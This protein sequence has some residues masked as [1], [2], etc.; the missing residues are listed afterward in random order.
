M[1]DQNFAAGF[2]IGIQVDANTL[3]A[4]IAGLS[5]ALTSSD[6][7][8]LGVADSG[9]GETGIT[10]PNFARDAVEIADVVGSFTRQP[11][12]FE[13]VGVDG[14]DITWLLK[15]NGAAS[16]PAAGEAKP[17]AGIDA[18]IEIAGLDGANGTSPVYEY[19][20]AIGTTYGTIKLWVGDVAYVFKACVIEKMLFTFLGGDSVKVT[21]S[22]RIGSVESVTDGTALPT[23]DYTTQS[24]LAAPVLKDAGVDWGPTRGFDKMDLTVNNTLEEFSDSNQATGVRLSQTDR[25]IEMDA[26]IYVDDTDTDYEYANLSASAAPTDDAIFQLGDVAAPTDT[27]NGTKVEFNNPIADNFQP[28]RRGDLLVSNVVAHA[29]GTAAGNEFMLTFN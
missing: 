18:L 2:A 20:P 3:N 16:T 9:T 26:V 12:S 27:I 23:F 19:T 7:I 28:D 6:G 21:S 10:L 4:T 8:V 22:I 15:G 1:A 14:F 5:G 24:S 25:S 17:L 29:T 11:S 13:K